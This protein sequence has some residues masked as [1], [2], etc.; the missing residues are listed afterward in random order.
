MKSYVVWNNK[1]GVGKSTIIFNLAS[2]YADL[3]S[4]K[5]VLVIDLCPQANSTMMFLG[6][7][8]VGENHLL[9][10]QTSSNTVVGY[11]DEKIRRTSGDIISQ[12]T[13]KVQVSNYNKN[14]PDNLWLVSGDGNL[15]LIAPAIN[16]YANAQIPSNAWRNVHY[17][18]KNLISEITEDSDDWVVF[19]DTNPSFAI[20]TELAIVAATHLIVPFK[21][22]DSSR[23]ATKALF[24]LL[25]GSSE[26]HPVYSKYTFAQKAKENEIILP[27]CHLFIGNQFVR[28]EAAAKAFHA[29]SDAVVS[30]LYNVYKTSSYRF[31]SKGEINSEA[32]FNKQFI[33][34]LKDFNSA[35][36]V[37]A[38]NGKL[39]H[40]LHD[41][42]EHLVHDRSL[43]LSPKTITNS[44]ESVEEIVSLL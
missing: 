23:V 35:G 37:A 22:D 4:N 24:D 15:E 30:D 40:K 36:V 8:R 42:R 19:I 38:N 39:L 34:E 43:G 18:I 12:N 1:G 5:K 3:N 31:T 20:H 33:K 41:T 16:Y 11:I 17:W 44:S 6:G 28:Y 25:Y 26:P 29:I 7:G 9:K 13:Y 21:A 2:R 14:L 10:L 27:L 32:D